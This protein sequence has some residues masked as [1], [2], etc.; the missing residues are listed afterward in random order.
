MLHHTSLLGVTLAALIGAAATAGCSHERTAS[1]EPPPPNTM[2]LAQGDAVGRALLVPTP[3]QA[4]ETA[5]AQV[6]LS[7]AD[8]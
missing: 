4:P 3:A 6:D 7:P 1:A 5:T 8:E 2:A